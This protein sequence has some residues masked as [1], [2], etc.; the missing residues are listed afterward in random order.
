[1]NVK[2]HIAFKN[3]IAEITPHY[4]DVINNQKGHH[5]AVHEFIY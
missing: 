1:M 5:S 3:T 2:Q 4:S